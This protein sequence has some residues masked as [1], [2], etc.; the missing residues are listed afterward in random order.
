M[1]SSPISAA[2]SGHRADPESGGRYR[3]DDSRLRRATGTSLARSRAA[4]VAERRRQSA[5][6]TIGERRG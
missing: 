1:G 4:S 3:E 5:R 6:G 2:P